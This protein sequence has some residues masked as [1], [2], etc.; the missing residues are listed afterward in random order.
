MDAGNAAT[1]FIEWVY[2]N[3]GLPPEEYAVKCSEFV[4]EAVDAER[5]RVLKIAAGVLMSMRDELPMSESRG[6]ATIDGRW[7]LTHA[8]WRNSHGSCEPETGVRDLAAVD[9]KTGRPR[10][11]LI[12]HRWPSFTKAQA[13]I[14]KGLR[15]GGSPLRIS[16]VMDRIP[17][18]SRV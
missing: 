8:I 3:P 6:E 10:F 16:E 12:Q 7:L 11:D 9:V 5:A 14:E 17:R 2:E 18:K 15:K 4:T 13:V 1:L